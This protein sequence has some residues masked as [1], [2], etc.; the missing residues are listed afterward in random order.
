MS[1]WTLFKKHR[2]ICV[3]WS[4]PLHREQLGLLGDIKGQGK[5]I[6]SSQ[7][8]CLF[9][10]NALGDKSLNSD[11]FAVKSESCSLLK[12]SMKSKPTAEEKAQHCVFW[13]GWYRLSWCCSRG[14]AVKALSRLPVAPQKRGHRDV[15]PTRDVQKYSQFKQKCLRKQYFPRFC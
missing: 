6:K 13:S 9:K 12:Q 3:S 15:T 14:Q 7:L 11:S 4:A 1:L 10:G 5:F 2:G 8:I